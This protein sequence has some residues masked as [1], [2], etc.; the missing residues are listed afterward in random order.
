[1]VTQSD[2]SANEVQAARAVML[3][4]Y[5]L[6]GEYRG[7]LVV[8][9]GWVPDLL[10]P[11]GAEPHVGSLD[12]D[13]A[14]NHRSIPEQGYKTIRELLESRGYQ[15]GEQPFIFL[16]TVIVQEREIQVQVD[17]LAGEYGGTGKS[18][19]TQTAQDMRPRKARGADL[20]FENPTG[21]ILE[22]VLP[23]GGKDRARIFVA[24][25]PSF[26]IMKS[27]ALGDRLKEKDAYDIVY[28]LRNNPGGID[29]LSDAL[30]AL[31]DH[32]LV[33]ES[34]EI[35]AEKFA[36]PESVGPVHAANFQEISDPDERALVQRDAYERVQALLEALQ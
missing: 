31:A 7:H 26:L 5:R 24:S 18:H 27:F 15:Q 14:V 34:L 22:S 6:L 30:K 32:N 28:C 21:T 25:I 2:Y 33:Q 9:G 36:D 8:I 3:E 17:F 10:I 20:A 23:E 29:P 35:L 4:L 11:A 13:L 1:M 12:V 19:R 16:K